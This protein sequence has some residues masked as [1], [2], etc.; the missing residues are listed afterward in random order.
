MFARVLNKPLKSDDYKK[1]K[2]DLRWCTIVNEDPQ[3]ARKIIKISIRSPR[4]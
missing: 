1:T 3:G 2:N 4:I